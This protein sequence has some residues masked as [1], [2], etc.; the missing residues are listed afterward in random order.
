ME[1]VDVEEANESTSLVSGGR[2]TVGSVDGAT[3][4][5]H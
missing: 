3:L 5:I 1:F 2:I 4:Y